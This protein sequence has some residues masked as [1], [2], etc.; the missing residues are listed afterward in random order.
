MEVVL[1]IQNKLLLNLDGLVDLLGLLRFYNHSLINFLLFIR[2]DS[3]GTL[4]ARMLNHEFVRV[5]E[6]FHATE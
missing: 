6:G 1:D 2:F 3:I 4:T 5:F